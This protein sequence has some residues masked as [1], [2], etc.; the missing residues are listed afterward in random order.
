MIAALAIALT[1]QTADV[2]AAPSLAELLT[3]AVDQATPGKRAAKAKSLAKRRDVT[4]E[5]WLGAMRGF[6]PLETEAARGPSS[7]TERL[8][9]G[10]AKLDIELHLYVPESYD[11][12]RAA[13]LLCAY[14]GTGGS[15]AGLY[16]MWQATCD[17]LG[18]LLLAPTDAG[19]NQGYRF[20]DEERDQALA[21]LRWMRRHFNVDEDR[22]ALTG[23]SRGG[24][25]AWDL[26]LRYPDRFAAI[27]PMIGGPRVQLAR[28]QNNMRYLENVTQLPIRDLQGSRDDPGLV[29]NLRQAFQTLARLGARDAE[30][31]EFEA[32]GHSFEMG[33]V[34]WP[35]F[36]GGV[37]REPLPG[38]VVLCTTEAP[39][40]ASW[41]EV[42][43]LGK[44]VDE[45]FTP[46]V[47]ASEWN[48]LDEA[49]R[50]AWLVRQAD[51]R[52][53]RCEVSVTARG[54]YLITAD[55]VR[56]VRLLLTAEQLDE[57]GRVHVA[58]GETNVKKRPRP[59]KA[60]LLTEFVE[61]FDRRFLPIYE[62]D[63][64]GR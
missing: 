9:V 5:D 48:R 35:A 4:L 43:R 51:E 57:D 59:S 62:V 23:I 39:S 13:P 47:E 56:A 12:S 30:L 27:A 26:A 64:R 54:R 44:G 42:T 25:L 6:E 29:T 52:T 50:R 14:H 10:N 21:A 41:L 28:G 2:E 15:G 34:D 18:M 11:P 38:R 8:R 49:G 46:K 16:R 19:E 1:L 45:T 17:E 31:I 60:V 53:A 32:L 20:S 55:K 40:R 7:R 24:H 58:F 63:V 33:A 61:R 22:I 3:E 37:A 36:L